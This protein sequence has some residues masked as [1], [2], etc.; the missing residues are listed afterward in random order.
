M[1][2]G[3]I[4]VRMG[5]RT[6]HVGVFAKIRPGFIYYENALP[7]R[8]ATTQGSVTRFA[9]TQASWN[10]GETNIRCESTDLI[11]NAR[12]TFMRDLIT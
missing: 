8:G 4:G 3:L 12:S 2:E 9:G 6:E 5:A 1:L 7:T 11:A 10:G